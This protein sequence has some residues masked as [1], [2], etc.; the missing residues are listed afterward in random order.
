W[1]SGDWIRDEHQQPGAG[2]GGGAQGGRAL[3]QWIDPAAGQHADH[4]TG[5]ADRS[6]SGPTAT[7][8]GDGA[9]RRSA[10]RSRDPG[11]RARGDAEPAQRGAAPAALST[12]WEPAAT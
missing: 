4:A 11:T 12:A 7:I 2:D 9:E 6:D 5:R 3:P 10:R 8:A 1:R